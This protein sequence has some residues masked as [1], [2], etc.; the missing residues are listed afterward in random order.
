[1]RLIVDDKSRLIF[2]TIFIMK[3]ESSNVIIDQLKLSRVQFYKRIACLMKARLVRRHKGKYFLTSYGTVIYDTQK[4]LESAI[5][6][7]W[8]LK[9]ID[10]IE[11]ANKDD[12]TTEERIKIIDQ[13]I[14]NQQIKKI[15]LTRP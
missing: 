6:N 15:L 7:Y 2:G 10:L 11:F 9:S 8:K 13:L 12:I 14:T 3:G 1:M 4:L 5:K